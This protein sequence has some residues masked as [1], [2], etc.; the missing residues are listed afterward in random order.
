MFKMKKVALTMAVMAALM[1]NGNVNAAEH[2]S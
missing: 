1:N 2:Q